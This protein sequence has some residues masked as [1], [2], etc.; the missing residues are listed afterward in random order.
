MQKRTCWQH[1][2]SATWQTKPGKA[3]TWNAQNRFFRLLLVV[4]VSF[5]L[6]T[7]SSSV[8]AGDQSQATTTQP[9]LKQQLEICRERGIAFLK[10]SQSPDGSW[11]ARSAPGITA[12]VTVS[13]LANGLSP[14][15]PTVAKALQHLMSHIKPDGGI[16]AK[17]SHHRNYETCLALLA[18]QLANKDGRYT[19]IVKN[20]E[21]FLRNLQWDEGEGLESSDP[22]YGGAGYGSHERPDLSNTQFL[23]EALKAVGAGPDDPAIKKALIFVSR[24][25]N[26]ESEYNTLPFA[27]KVNDG[28]FYYT[29]AS[30]GQSKAGTTP[31][32]GL[33][34]YG[35][36]TYAGLKS[37]IYAGWTSQDKRVKAALEWA[38]R[39][40]TLNENPG[41]GQQGLFYYYQMF[42]KALA[43]A[44]VEK[45]VDANGVSHDWR[46]ELIETLAKLQRPNGSWVNK[47]H[48]W[49]EGDPHLVTAYA[50]LALAYA[51]RST[52]I[53][54]LKKKSSS[55]SKATK[56]AQP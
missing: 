48:R 12:V 20:A 51:D 31:N 35:S 27:G 9:S 53:P 11:T 40:Y 7:N 22:R 52:E 21:K 55:S 43:A 2:S 47:A 19:K 26:L 50:L 34:S 41:M 15:D 42:A 8:F 25:Q 28:G 10:A 38:A 1:S 30:G 4:F 6:G 36:M 49:Y 3:V 37:M 39:H 56:K 46:A 18:F 44:G 5:A 45:L 23:I 16:Y 29:A 17:R 13:L 54:G 32:G 33:R 24:C 14:D